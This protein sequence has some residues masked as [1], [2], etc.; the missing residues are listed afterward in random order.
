L[1]LQH[2]GV[3]YRDVAGLVLKDLTPMVS[4]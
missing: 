2:I 3:I 1:P 4:Q